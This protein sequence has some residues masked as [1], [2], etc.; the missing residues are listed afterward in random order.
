MT[1]THASA[2]AW[3]D[4]LG[5]TAVLATTAGALP[6]QQ[7]LRDHRERLAAAL[8]SLQ[9]RGRGRLVTVFPPGRLQFINNLCSSLTALTAPLTPH[10]TDADCLHSIRPDVAVLD[11]ALPSVYR[12]L[13]RAHGISMISV[14]PDLDLHLE[15]CVPHPAPKGRGGVADRGLLLATSGTEGE[16]KRVHLTPA[17]LLRVARRIASSLQLD[18]DDRLLSVLPGQHIHGYSTAL[19][20]LL[21]G[22]SVHFQE[23]FEARAVLDRLQDGEVSWV[24]ATPTHYR[25]LLHAL[26]ESGQRAAFPRLRLLRSA[27]APMDAALVNR[28]A[29][30]FAVPVL[31]AYGMTEAG[32]LIASNTLEDGGN[33][34]GSVGRP[35]G[36]EVRIADAA[37][38][39]AQADGDIWI[40]G[41]CVVSAYWSADD[42]EAPGTDP[43]GWLATGDIGHFDR[44]GFLYVTG[45][46]RDVINAGGEKLLPAVIESVLARHPWVREVVVYP[47]P[48]ATLGEAPR[49]VVVPADSRPPAHAESAEWLREL[50]QL[51]AEQLPPSHVPQEIIARSEIPV[52]PTGKIRRRALHA[53]LD[54]AAPRDP[55]PASRGADDLRRTL[56]RCWLEVLPAGAKRDGDN[57]FLRGGDSL[58][59]AALIAALEERLGLALGDDFV[60]RWPLLEEQAREIASRSPTPSTRPDTPPQRPRALGSIAPLSPGQQRLW[61]LAQRGAGAQYTM[62]APLQLDGELRID[63]LEAALADV[64]ARH[65]ALR[66]CVK[67]LDARPVQYITDTAM[68]RLA[69]HDL[70]GV[71]AASRTQRL[72]GEELAH[73]FDPASAPPV[74]YLL[75]RVADRR[76]VFVLTIHHMFCDGWS[77]PLFYRDLLVS[78]ARRIGFELSLPAPG[79]DHADFCHQQAL[80]AAGDDDHEHLAWWQAQLSGIE[81]PLFTA[82]GATSD[83]PAHGARSHGEID[84]RLTAQLRRAAGDL[85]T[86]RHALLL[87][88]L[89]LAIARHSGRRRFCVGTV[90]AHRTERAFE[91]CIGFLANTLA[92]PAH[93]DPQD[94]LQT[95]AASVARLHRET[96]ARGDVD[97][98]RVL[99]GLA[100]S[101]GSEHPLVEVMLAHQNYPSLEARLAALAD[102]DGLP[103]AVPHPVDGTLARFPLTL[104]ITPG[105]DR[106]AITWQYRRAYFSAADIAAIAATFT[107]ALRALAAGATHTVGELLG[108]AR[109]GT[110]ARCAAPAHPEPNDLLQR[111]RE[112][113]R[114][115]PQVTALACDG[116]SRT[117]AQLLADVEHAAS[118]LERHGIQRGSRVGVLLPRGIEAIVAPLALWL[119]G[120]TYVPIDCAQP[121]DRLQHMLRDAAVAL[122]LYAPRTAEVAAAAA[123]GADIPALDWA[124]LV[125][126]D[127]AA[128][129]ADDGYDPSSVAYIIFTSGTTGLP[130]GVQISRASLAHY[131]ASLAGALQVAAGDV[132]LH[133]APLSFSSS[134]RQFAVPLY[135]G[136]R[137]QMAM[138]DEVRNAARLPVLARD[139][140]ATILD[141]VPSHWRNVLRASA[142]SEHRAA[143]RCTSL[144]LLLSASEALDVRLAAQIEAAFPGACLVNMYGQ[145][146][147]AGIVLLHPVA[148]DD[149]AAAYVAL[150]TP[151]EGCGCAVVTAAGDEAEDGATGELVVWGPTVGIG[152][153]STSREASARF[154]RWRG[155]RAYRSGDLVRRDENGC[156][157][158]VGR[159]DA[160][161]KHRGFRIE[162]GDVE[163]VAMR[164]PALEGCVAALVT[165]GSDTPQL[166][167]YYSAPSVQDPARLRAELRQ[168]AAAHLPPYMRPGRYIHLDALPR[169]ISGK[170]DRDAVARLHAATD[171]ASTGAAA[172]P[173]R[174]EDVVAMLRRIWEEELDVDEIRAGDNFFDLGGDSLTSIAVVAR[175]QDLGLPL[176]LEALFRHQTIDALAA[177]V[178][179]A[180]APAASAG[181]TGKQ[182]PVQDADRTAP[183]RKADTG[184]G[185]E[186]MRRF[187][188]DSLRALSHEIL[189]QAGL[190]T[191]GVR[192]LTEVQLESSLRGQMTHN[193]GDIPRYAARLHSGVL[194]AR[195]RIRIDDDSPV[196]ARVDGDNAPGQW[197]AS[198]AMG[199][200]MELARER[201][202]GMVA[203]RRSNHFGA[204]GHY[205]WQAAGAGLIGLCFSNG[206]VILAPTGGTEPLFGNN[207]LAIGIPRG[208]T[209]PLVLDIAMS[210]ATRGKIGLTV[211]E[212]RPLEPGWIL[213]RLGMPSTSLEDLAAGLATPIGGHKG[214]GLAFAIEVL[215]GALTGAGYCAD[216]RGAAA[217][218]HGGSDIGHLFIA[219]DPDVFMPRDRFR[220]RVDDIVQQTKT[221]TRIDGVEEIFVPGEMEMKAR[222]YNLEH[223]VPLPASAVRRLRDYRQRLGIASDLVEQAASRSS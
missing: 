186:T 60:L 174:L 160:Q 6:A 34:P 153:C 168:L 128:R 138:A 181:Q 200:A 201:G 71:D 103:K 88:A 5:P 28:L 135:A 112:H 173:E 187:T 119:H 144:R 219:L 208:E 41:D 98:A 75:L 177:H 32:P 59:A 23:R 178:L 51:C 37:D 83:D 94:S 134:V 125:D 14:T 108:E 137:V 130:K 27:S 115:A 223:G 170:V 145:T 31:Q 13:C 216:H 7:T 215:A 123:H 22:G 191:E 44:D 106:L 207:P 3:L 196:S 114:I 24:S 35:C 16:A 97:L 81:Q 77:V 111:L 72:I 42:R 74:R 166:G 172:P 182:A 73:E 167:L 192:I 48:H 21:A 99:R 146:E 2:D 89:Q 139:S 193:I 140:G 67:F 141:L 118:G 90:V 57:F 171:T 158:F 159:A 169:T 40:R 162:P 211:A 91:N 53:L 221:S 217:A 10:M 204:A 148:T 50:R 87:A 105:D 36:V 76:H 209:H 156:I 184:A 220:A 152:Y 126:H 45:R 82:R 194:N 65:D 129:P 109:Q 55:E 120:A 4:D 190:A 180:Q 151:L 9:P 84:A 222:A 1:D 96:M 189:G 30:Q 203:V 142:L 20:A 62:C 188:P 15:A 136:A 202:V 63:T 100:R 163:A 86:S 150:G 127:R 164:H 155:R 39:A 64:V 133:T 206:P 110:P 66:S 61:Y 69:H 43:E 147:T 38:G 161:L 210:V 199:R 165:A 101:A 176:S 12:D 17:V 33:R 132:Y 102:V 54:S 19:A 179:R 8:H 58:S 195:P 18:G 143:G 212:G 29:E 26:G 121:R 175:A 11:A 68:P 117:Y 85:G 116:V 107:A 95:F 92:V 198:L 47:A 46:R 149:T 104:Y 185:A 154:C 79:A 218:R 183:A 70:R 49:A 122:L 197:V 25:A 78:Y 205:A 93:V 124:R 80:R 214:Y 113:A 56:E 52:A 131:V 213:D 157:H